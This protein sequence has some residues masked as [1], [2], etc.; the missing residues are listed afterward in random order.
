MSIIH[1]TRGNILEAEAEALVNTVN[2]VGY[3]GK[4][5]ALQFKRA[6]PDN[7]KKYE[8]ACKAGEVRPGRMLIYETGTLH[9]P[10][11]VVNFPTKR[12]WRGKSSI[13]DVRAGLEALV[14]EIKELGI[15][16]IAVPP[17][18]CGLGGLNWD[19]VRPLIEQALAPIPDL[20]VH[21]YSPGGAP[22]PKS[23][24]TRTTRPK[25]TSARA[26]FVKLMHQYSGM[27]YRLSLLEVQKLVYFLQEGGEPLRLEFQA[28]HDGPYAPHLN[29]VLIRIEGHFTRGCGDSDK[30]DLEMELVPGAL[31][32]ADG[33]LNDSLARESASRL[34]RVEALIE[35][36]ETPY[37]MELLSSLHWLAHHATP[38]LEDHLDATNK[39]KSWNARKNNL[40]Q[41]RHV[42]VAWDRLVEL[43]WIAR[44]GTTGGLLHLEAGGKTLRSTEEPMAAPG[45]GSAA[46]D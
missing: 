10:R 23:I 12:H 16:S 13:E 14:D 24:P 3:M 5:I 27:A 36:F 45:R 19:E 18:G 41:E 31:E 34:S 37:G 6:Y 4:G 20:M 44:G 38:R 21:L 30:P 22:E 39:L 42:K 11:Y 28:G 8:K 2:C 7:F 35:G 40:F 9:S 43:G 1:H 46:V 26:L 15:K 29:K 32:E 17:L 33:F 25:M